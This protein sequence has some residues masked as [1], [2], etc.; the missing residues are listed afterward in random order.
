MMDIDKPIL[1]T[2]E[3]CQLIE[4]SE[5]TLKDWVDAGYIRRFKVGQVVRYM[6]RQ[7]LEDLEALAVRVEA[8]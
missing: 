3:A 5:H 2:R 1:T 4:V 8:T 6:R 7:L